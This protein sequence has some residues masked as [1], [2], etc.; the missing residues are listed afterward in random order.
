MNKIF[1]TLFLAFLCSISLSG[2]DLINKAHKFYAEGN[3]VE[4]LKLLTS[5]SIMAEKNP[6]Y[7]KMLYFMKL[8]SEYKSNQFDRSL[9]SS[10][11]YM[12]NFP[13]SKESGDAIMILKSSLRSIKDL[14]KID[15]SVFKNLKVAGL[16]KIIRKDLLSKLTEDNDIKGLEYFSPVF[17]FEQEIRAANEKNSKIT[18]LSEF[19]RDKKYEDAK[20]ILAELKGTVEEKNYFYKFLLYHEAIIAFD[21]KDSTSAAALFKTLVTKYPNSPFTVPVL[22]TLKKLVPEEELMGIVDSL[23]EKAKDNQLLVQKITFFKGRLLI[24]G[25]KFEQACKLL[26][27]SLVPEM[28]DPEYLRLSIL[29]KSSLL[30]VYKNLKDENKLRNLKEELNKYTDKFPFL[31]KLLK[32]Y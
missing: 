15:L 11:R 28:D 6:E 9:E 22:N 5:E 23:L 12:N 1:F 26:E 20:K 3:S 13:E 24:Q 14:K 32:I 29:V 7:R 4:A 2:S 30:L 31:T 17:S 19:I 21:L 16:K 25:K 10:I 8:S 27:K 18:R